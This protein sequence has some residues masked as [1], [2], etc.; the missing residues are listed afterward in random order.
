MPD[1]KWDHELARVAQRWAD[2][3]LNGRDKCRSVARFYVGQNRGWSWRNKPGGARDWTRR[4]VGRWF[5]GELPFFRQKDLVFRRGKDPAT[6]RPIGHMTQVIW[7][8]TTR[9]GCGFTNQRFGTWVM[10]S[11]FC[12]SGPGG[13]ILNQGIY[14]RDQILP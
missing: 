8:A 14:Q 5:H 3:C 13:N 2:Q 12:N 7:A 1:L 11:Y 10:R 4:A 9:I 6:G